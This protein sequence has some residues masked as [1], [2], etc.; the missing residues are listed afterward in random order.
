MSDYP[1]TPYITLGIPGLW[2]M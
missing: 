1:E 2:V